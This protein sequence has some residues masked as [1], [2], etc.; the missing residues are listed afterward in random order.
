MIIKLKRCSQC[1]KEK[2]EFEFHLDHH[3]SD[4]LY[5]L[6]KECKNEYQR[7]Q[8]YENTYGFLPG[9]FKKISKSQNYECLICK[10]VKKLGYDKEHK[11]YI[12]RG[13]L[14]NNCNL[15]LGWFENHSIKIQEYLNK[16]EWK[17]CLVWLSPR[18]RKDIDLRHDH[19]ICLDDFEM[20]FETQNGV[21]GICY[22]V[23]STNNNL[24]VDHDYQTLRVRGLLCM[25][26]NTKLGWYEKY[27]V[28]EY[29]E[30]N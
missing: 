21:C 28:Q 10:Q 17:F 25:S 16:S 22:K 24:C 13:L 2:P 3:T 27:P 8:H 12:K 15:K 11:K 7:N 4:G 29:L 20:M 9:G 30:N 5:P 18:N 1:K 23:C 19:Y 6:C 14:C 26:C